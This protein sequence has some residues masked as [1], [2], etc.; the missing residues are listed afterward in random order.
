MWDYVWRVD[1]SLSSLNSRQKWPQLNVIPKTQLL[2]HEERQP[3]FSL[4]SFRLSFLY[5]V[6]EKKSASPVFNFN[7]KKSPIFIFFV[8]PSQ[9]QGQFN[10]K[11]YHC[12]QKY[13]FYCLAKSLPRCYLL[14]CFTYFYNLDQFSCTIYNWGSRYALT[15]PRRRNRQEI[16]TVC[17]E[18]RQVQRNQG[19]H[20]L[21]TAWTNRNHVSHI[22]HRAPNYVSPHTHP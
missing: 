5:Y 10:F 14:T 3:P 20:L 4:S 13:I 11:L 9:F 21:P 15:T 1:N 7:Q 19:I 6:S 18:V 17:I 22:Y 12:T 16:H 8:H 2:S